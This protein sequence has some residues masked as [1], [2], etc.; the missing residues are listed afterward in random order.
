MKTPALLFLVLLSGTATL[1]AQSTINSTNRYAYAANLG[2]VDARGD[3]TN[4]VVVG[5]YVCSGYAYGANVGWINFGSG[6]ATNRVYY[7]NTSAT[8]FGIN[9][10]GTGR[11]RG[12]AYGANIGWI[13]F[14]DTGNPVVNLTNGQLSGYAYSANCGWINLGQF[15][16]AVVTDIIRRGFSSSAD[17]IPD[18]WKILNFGPSW[19]TNP[20]ALANA[21]PDGDGITNRQEYLDGTN[22]NNPNSGLRITNVVRTVG[23]TTGT[24][25]V[26]WTSI[27]PSSGYTYDVQKNV[28]LLPATPWV[29]SGLGVVSPTLGST[30]TGAPSILTSDPQ[31]FYRVRSFQTAL[32]QPPLP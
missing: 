20:N 6:A 18:A 11:L 19:A 13:N 23:M 3:T 2:W 24:V 10:D 5:E 27:A 15:T 9:Q 31:Y 25:A 30:T 4:G 14:E 17:G 1:S 32:L 12:Y 26:T 7:S 8:D 29:D 22:P 16:Q 21:D 28:D